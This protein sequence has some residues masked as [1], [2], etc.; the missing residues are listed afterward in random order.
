[1]VGDDEVPEEK[2]VAMGETK[3][4]SSPPLGLGFAFAARQGH[5]GGIGIGIAGDERRPGRSVWAFRA[6]RDRALLPSMGAVA[7]RRRQAFARPLV[8][9][10]QHSPCFECLRLDSYVSIATSSKLKVGVLLLL[11]PTPPMRTSRTLRAGAEAGPLRK[12]R[13]N[14]SGA[15]NYLG[16]L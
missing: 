3:E 5:I 9:P 14:S 4:A 1:M 11:S 15:L 6:M 13:L 16:V 8:G 7:R 12:E 2:L 10:P